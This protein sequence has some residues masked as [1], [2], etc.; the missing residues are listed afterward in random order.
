MRKSKFLAIISLIL[1][2]VMIVSGLQIWKTLSIYYTSDRVYADLRPAETASQPAADSSLSSE[3]ADTACNP[4]VDF[5]KLKKINPDLVG[6]I[7][8]P[9]TKI[10]YPIVQGSDNTYYLQHLFTKEKNRAGCIFLDSR[11]S[12]GF[13]DLHSILYGHHMKNIAMFSELEHYEKQSF[14]DAHPVVWILTPD[15]N[16]QL[17]LFSGYITKESAN[18]WQ[19]FSTSEEESAWITE[20]IQQSAF[21]SPVTPKAGDP[22]VTLSTCS[23]DFENARFVLHGVLTKDPPQT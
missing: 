1:A 5:T 20:T 10:N 3:E 8:L 12:S 21:Q 23:Y 6:W 19:L 22:I 15:K 16:Y 17:Q 18:A 4:A 11:N 9:D 13:S 14:Y 7:Y 2:C